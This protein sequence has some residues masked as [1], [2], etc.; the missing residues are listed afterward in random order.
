MGNAEILY[1]VSY[2]IGHG[3]NAFPP[4]LNLKRFRRGGNAQGREK[5]VLKKH[6]GREVPAGYKRKTDI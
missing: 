2:G 1:R 5:G 6:T 4:R 3:F